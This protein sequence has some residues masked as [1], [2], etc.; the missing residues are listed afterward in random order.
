M[1][2]ETLNNKDRLILENQK[3][4]LHGLRALLWGVKINGPAMEMQNGMDRT[5]DFLDAHIRE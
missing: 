4:I 1:A 5:H 2:H 3:L